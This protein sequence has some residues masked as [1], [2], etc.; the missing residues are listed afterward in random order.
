MSERTIQNELP[1]SAE[2]AVEKRNVTQQDFGWEVPVTSVPVPSEGRVYPTTSN[3]HGRNILNIKAMTAREE[4][5]LT[6]RA[7]INQGTV[8]THL[9][10]SC[11]IDKDVDVDDLLLGDRNA[12]M[13]SVRITGYGSHYP[14]AVVCPACSAQQTFD[15][16]LSE[17]EVKRLGIEPISPGSNL[18]EYVLPV[19]GKTV[20]FKFLTGHDE[21]EMSLT[22][23]RKKKLMPGAKVESLVTGRLEHV[24][25]SIDGVTDR[26]KINMFIQNMPAL[27]SRKLRTYIDENEPGIDM[28][29]WMECQQCST[30]SQV[31]LPVGIGFF[32]PQT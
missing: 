7:L 27:D 21:R 29:A 12:L 20:H 9:L 10:N 18:F 30:E 1:S 28:N 19:S 31:P 24:I 13:I 15:F 25:E 23:E 2:Q 8:I 6:S 16:D 22:A 26:N 5:I 3:M 11:L 14:A 32:W 4:D 17:L